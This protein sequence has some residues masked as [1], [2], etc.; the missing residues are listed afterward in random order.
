MIKMPKNQSIKNSIRICELINRDNDKL[1]LEKNK[2]TNILEIPFSEG[3]V[4][5]RYETQLN[6]IN[7]KI[8]LNNEY[9]SAAEDACMNDRP[10]TIFEDRYLFSY[11]EADLCAATVIENI[12][13]DDDVLDK[14]R[15]GL[16]DKLEIKRNLKL[17]ENNSNM[18]DA[19]IDAFIHRRPYSIL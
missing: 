16:T 4:K 1:N 18:Y 13:K 15:K 3:P 17:K 14:E 10:F 8:T 9:R 19:Y 11:A 12:F 5:T 6:E 2:L 7:Q